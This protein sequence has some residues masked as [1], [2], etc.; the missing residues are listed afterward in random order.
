MKKKKIFFITTELPSTKGGASTRNFNILKSLDKTKFSISLFTIVSNKTKGTLNSVRNELSIPIYSVK[1]HSLSSTKQLFYL[2]TQKIIP[3]M[4]E[5]ELSHIEK[6][7]LKKLKEKKPD[8]VHIEQL[9]TFYA[10]RKIIPYLKKQNITIILDQHNVENIAFSEG[11]RSMPLIKRLLGKLILTNIKRGIAAARNTGLKNAKGEIYINFDDDCYA[12]KNWLK[13]LSSGYLNYEHENIIG[14]SGLIELIGKTRIIDKYIYEIGYGN[15]SPVA[16]VKT[17]NIFTRFSAYLKNMFSITNKVT[18]TISEV[19]EIWGANSSFPIAVLKKIK[20]WDENLSGVEDTD[21]CNRIKKKFPEKKFVCIKNAI[22]YHDHKL[23]LHKFIQKPYL[24]GKVI[25]KFYLQNL[26]T[27][28]IFPFPLAI[29]LS[30]A[31]TAVF[32]PFLGL[33]ALILLPLGFYSWWVIKAIK[34]KKLYL[35]TFPYLQSGYEL[36]SILGLLKGFIQMNTNITPRKILIM[37]FIFGI[38]VNCLTLN[39]VNYFF[40]R[41]FLSTL[42]LLFIPGFLISWAIKIKYKNI[43]DIITFTLGLSLAALMLVGLVVN[44]LLPLINLQFIHVLKPLALQPM[45]FSIDLMLI[46]LC[47][48]IYKHNISTPITTTSIPLSFKNILLGII[49]TSLPALSVIG[50][51][52][53]NSN[54]SNIYT[55]ATLGITAIYVMFLTIARNK[56]SQHLLIYSIFN[57]AIS[58]LLMTSLR[59]WYI[60]GHDIFLEYYVFQLTKAHGI[61]QMINFQDPYNACLSITILPTIISN[62]THINDFYIYKALYQIIFSFSIVATYQFIKRFINP[63]LAFLGT[64]AI[65]SLPTFMTDMPM[66]NRQEIAL[67]FFVLLFNTLFNNEFS[68]KIKWFLFLIFGF[69]LLLSHYSTTYI[70]IGLFAGS[71]IACLA[72]NIIKLHPTTKTLI[73][74]ID[75]KLGLIDNK[76]NLKLGMIGILLIATI[77]WNVNITNTATGI[78]TTINKVTHDLTTSHFAKAKNDPGSYGLL[79]NKAPSGQSLL[80]TYIDT[81]TQYVRKFNDDSAFLD[82]NIYNQYQVNVG[83]QIKQPLTQL[84]QTLNVLHINV[85]EL[86]NQLKQTYAKLIQ[87]FIVVGFVAIFFY[88]KNI[89]HFEKEYLIL[90]LTF[91]AILVIQVVLP[92]ASIDYG[93][94][95]LFQQGL[96]LFSIPLLMGGLAIFSI[97]NKIHKSIKVY[98]LSFTF[99]FFF[100]YLSGFI[101]AITGGYYPQLN[102]ANAGFYYDAYY[103]HT[104]DLTAM[105]WLSN[106]RDKKIPVQS[107][108]FTLK[109]IHTYEQFYSI[110]G[111]IPSVIRRNSYVYLSVSNL[112]TRQVIIYANGTPLYYKYDFNF[113]DKNKNL[114]Y[115]NGGAKIYR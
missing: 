105:N 69:G 107:D 93:I 104:K 28:P 20:G 103:T 57:I 90:T 85:F 34:T 50:A 82:K 111:L 33:I 74:R 66:L 38:I 47:A 23:Q 64:F 63:F 44:Y 48:L 61:W 14:V 106:N 11:I 10:I 58:L 8:V 112:Q 84:G 18:E 59:S 5:Y 43:W 65:V 54:N 52:D 56:I 31:I 95:R 15:P 113:L 71:F 22:I 7:I 41:E 13:N 26:K 72:L 3:Y 108:W 29:L 101:P 21:L 60:T 94:L 51:I 1:H 30:S 83:S 55:L 77:V 12:D 4:K 68:K 9:N 2:L 100:L 32:N 81:T 46:I 75:R 80:N 36:A 96:I 86:N 6:L 110:D 62:I 67:L 88:K 49:P 40:I 87:I 89:R 19:G 70:A 109:K 79:N 53:L 76:P 17:K 102:L 114:I 35:L 24:R 25:L 42:Y 92:G 45:L 98:L 78:I 97:F 91:F 73:H 27:P 115:N 39:N 99:V 16:Y 37:I